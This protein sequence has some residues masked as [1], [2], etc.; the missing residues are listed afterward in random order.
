MISQLSEGTKRQVSCLNSTGDKASDHQVFFFF[1][2]FLLNP[3]S[4]INRNNTKFMC[5][6]LPFTSID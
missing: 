4:G 3:C 1:F 6:K 2:F 5:V